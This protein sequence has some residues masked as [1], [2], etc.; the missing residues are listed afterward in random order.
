L[1][2]VVVVV[3]QQ[4]TGNLNKDYTVIISEHCPIF[5]DIMQ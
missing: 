1:L 2:V 5:V 3:M 4:R